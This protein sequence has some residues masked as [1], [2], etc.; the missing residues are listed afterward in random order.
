MSDNRICEWKGITCDSVGNV[1]SIQLVEAGLEGTLDSS[2][3]QL[4]TLLELDLSSNAFTGSIPSQLLALPKIKVIDLRLNKLIGSIPLPLS[5]SMEALHLG[6]NALTGRPLETSFSSAGFQSLRILDLKYNQLEGTLPS[7]FTGLSA[8]QTFDLSN[9][10]FRGTIPSTLGELSTLKYLYLSNNLLTGTIPH[11]FGSA[12]IDLQQ[13]YLHGNFLTGTLPS[14][15]ADLGNLQILFIDNNKLTGTVPTELCALNLNELFFLDNGAE[16]VD[17]DS[18]YTEL[19]GNRSLSDLI[20]ER[21]GCTSIACP[22]GYKSMGDSKDGVYPCEPC[23]SMDLN[24]YIGANNCFEM[25]QDT[26]LKALYDATNG[27][28]W[29]GDADWGSNATTFCESH[30]VTCNSDQQVTSIVLSNKGLSGTLPNGLGFLEKLVQLDV[31]YNN[32]GG[33]LPADLQFAPLVILNVAENQLTGFVPS[34]LCRKSGVNGNGVDGL[35]SCDVITCKGGHMLQGRA[36]P[37]TSGDTCSVCVSGNNDYLGIID[38][39]DAPTGGV[40]S[41]PLATREKFV[42]QYWVLQWFAVLVLLRRAKVSKEYISNRAHYI[43][44]PEREAFEK[45]LRD[46]GDENESDPLAGIDGIDDLNRG[47]TLTLE[48][49]IKDE[50]NGDKESKQKDIWLDVPKIT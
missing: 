30:G 48:V 42:L 19:Y 37:G 3:G 35:Y 17:V 47:G 34:G 31:S 18:S 2:L 9:N 41:H 21:T 7:S 39:V 27:P 8:I 5:A 33:T 22:A 12:A 32:I 1:E 25:D 11:H 10:R 40:E 43:Q 26:I 15:L 4:T 16:A 38:C 36:D 50:W 24:P 6:H 44:S 29:T 46:N 13:I 45:P 20:S 14:S 23:A 28:S 49:K